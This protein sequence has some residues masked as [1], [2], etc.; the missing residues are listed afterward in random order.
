MEGHQGGE[1]PSLCAVEMACIDIQ[2]Y[3]EERYDAADDSEDANSEQ[4]TTPE[5]DEQLPIDGLC[6]ACD[7]GGELWLKHENNFGGPCVHPCVAK[8]LCVAKQSFVVVTAGLL[9]MCDGSCIRSFHHG[10]EECNVL[11]MP[12]VSGFSYSL[13][14]AMAISNKS[15]YCVHAVL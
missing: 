2:V 4:D 12:Q 15:A 7:D 9:L 5:D 11:G 13:L 10:M 6:A 1:V 8:K 3:G 14:S